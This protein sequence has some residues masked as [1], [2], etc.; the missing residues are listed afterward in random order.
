MSSHL[1]SQ[2]SSLLTPHFSLRFKETQQDGNSFFF[3]DLI[4]PAH[5]DT[6][7]DLSH[8]LR[9]QISVLFDRYHY[10]SHIVATVSNSSRSWAFLPAP[11]DAFR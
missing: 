8:F 6:F 7:Q 9:W 10:N 1:Q 11:D 2:S 4:S 3:H 5:I